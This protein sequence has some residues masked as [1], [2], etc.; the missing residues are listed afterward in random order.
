MLRYLPLIVKNALRNRRR[1]ILTICSIAASLCLL[2][3]LLA[4]FHAFYYTDPPAAQARRLVTRNKVSLAVPMPIFYRQRIQQ[5][6]GVQA[7]GVSQWFGGV[8]KDERDQNNFFARFAVEP[9]RL[10]QLYQEFQVSDA[11]KKAFLADRTGCMLG[12]KLAERLNI[13]LGDRLV[14]KGDIFPGNY[15]FTVR[16]LYDADENNENMYFNLDYLFES[17]PTGRRDFAGTFTILA[18]SVESVPRIAREIDDMF[19]NSTAQTKTESE[20]A[21]QLSFVAFLGNVKMFLLSICAAVTFTILLVSGNT[22]AMSVRERIREVGVL[23][24]LG[25]TPGAIL[26]IILGEA[27]F[28]SLIGGAIGCG[29]AWLMCGVVRHSPA[30]LT[31]LK[32]LTIV[33][34]VAVACLV[35]ALLIGLVSSLIPAWGASRTSILDSL[36]YTG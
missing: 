36:R 32:T 3:V 22:M 34:S 33:P 8:Y 29:L 17:L 31:Q 6:T 23:K 12:R 28:I 4:M 35:I 5:V 2:G 9:D 10:L 16:A 19:A 26:A 13:K 30:F 20:R 14:L 11:E 27:G 24:T 18:D 15:E 1:S 21:F 25:F 7:V